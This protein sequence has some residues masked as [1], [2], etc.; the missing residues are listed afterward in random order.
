[1]IDT[2]Y[3]RVM[4][5][6]DHFVFQT[7]KIGEIITL[8]CIPMNA[9]DSIELDMVGAFKLS[10]LSKNLALDPRVDIYS[11]YVPHRHIYGDEWVRFL[12][13]GVGTPSTPNT[14]SGSKQIVGAALDSL[15]F[16]TDGSI[17]PND[18]VD[19]PLWRF[20]GYINIYNNFFK[21]PFDADLPIENF[22]TRLTAQHLKNIWT[23]PLP[24]NQTVDKN[25]DVAVDTDSISI[26]QFALQAASQYTDQSRDLFMQRYRDVVD[27][28]GGSTTADVDNRPT[29][30]GK[31]IFRGSGYDV[32]GTTEGSLGTYIGRGDTSFRHQCNRFHCNEH[33]AIWTLAVV[34][35]DPVMAA[36][37]HYLSAK[38]APTYADFAGDPTVVGNMP[39]RE[40]TFAEF[41]SGS[42]FPAT[43]KLNLAHGQWWRE[44]ANFTNSRFSGSTGFPFLKWDSIGST[45][46]LSPEDYDP[47]FR[48][49]ELQHWQIYARSNVQTFRRIPTTRESA[50]VS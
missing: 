37:N 47:I 23:A 8:D 11:F 4:Y 43:G 12:R 21:R 33:G 17:A 9:G 41:M 6:L 16:S 19:L 28:F 39:I 7:G 29:M 18:L 10:P 42:T 35:Y 44:H 2:N 30:I 24:P 36:E 32:D 1:M 3:P 34:R 38:T 40:Y 46:T 48:D 22:G 27:S 26:Q 13:D 49:S 5:P 50:M 25:D 45:V 20:G 15:G 14:L 31:S